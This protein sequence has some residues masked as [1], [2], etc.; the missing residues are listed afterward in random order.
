MRLLYLRLSA[1][2]S[3]PMRVFVI[4]HRRIFSD[5]ME[6]FCFAFVAADVTTIIKRCTRYLMLALVA[7]GLAAIDAAV[8]VAGFI[9]PDAGFAIVADG[10]LNTFR[11]ASN[12]FVG[13]CTIY[14]ML[15][16]INEY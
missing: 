15:A 6:Y 13:I 10:S 7:K 4:L 14:N 8:P 1:Y 2:T 3:P 9:R 16:G 11:T 12:A 5:R